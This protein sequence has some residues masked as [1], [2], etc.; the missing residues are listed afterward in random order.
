M[1]YLTDE[2]LKSYLDT[3]QL[4]REQL[5]LA[6]LAL[7][8]RFAEVRP[9]HPRGGPDGGRDIEA[10]FRGDQVA[11]AAVGFVNQADDSEEKKRT[12]RSKFADDLTSA[13][14]N[15]PAPEVFVFF[16]NVNLTAGE[17]D[18]LI[19]S[20]KS[21]GI[22]TC[23]IFD[24]ERIRIALDSADGFAIRFQFLGMPLSEEEQASFFAKWG[25]DINSVIAT[26]F[27]KVQ[28]T[29]DHLLFLQ[30]AN[31]SVHSFQLAF[32]LHRKYTGE[33]IAHFR[34]FC[35][36]FLKEPKLNILSILF[37]SAD[38]PY[39]FD[40][41]TGNAREQQP[42]IKFGFSG[43]Q[44]E[45]QFGVKSSKAENGQGLE[46][47]EAEKYQ[48]DSTFSAAGLDTVQFLTIQYSKT[49]LFRLTPVLQ[50]R[51][52][53]DSMLMP[54]LNRSL[55]QIIKTIHVISNG[56]KLFEVSAERFYIDDTPFDPGIPFSFSDEE[57]ADPWVRIR[58]KNSSTFRLA[59]AEEI[60]QRLFISRRAQN[61]L[62]AQ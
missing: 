25:D 56:Y 40:N 45:Q 60:P 17:K 13:L 15:T 34:A 41:E 58:P 62:P 10:I 44:W 30:E 24:R 31:D 36:V 1:T 38:K 43:A 23:E 4:H 29:L 2:R 42:G 19:A 46:D 22:V 51:D 9:R 49:G 52:F 54:M 59:F 50:L 28:K 37:G 3:N 35:R 20:A 61:T 33:Q 12:I 32:E 6:V 39:R 26:G 18:Q 16:T 55:A 7:D 21:H 14:R 5:A 47:E 11:F 57:L 8:K 53:D 27:Q 48:R